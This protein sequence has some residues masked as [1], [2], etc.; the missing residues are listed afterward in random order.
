[1][2]PMSQLFRLASLFTL[3]TGL[4]AFLTYA[5]LHR[6]KRMARSFRERIRE[7]LKKRASRRP[8]AP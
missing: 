2:G 5:L 6:E 8:P 1:M 4:L 3:L 7:R